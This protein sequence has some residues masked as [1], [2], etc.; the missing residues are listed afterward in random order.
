MTSTS[1]EKTFKTKN[2]NVKMLRQHVW[3]EKRDCLC[4]SFLIS[5][6]N[7]QAPIPKWDAQRL[8]YGWWQW[9]VAVTKA[10]PGWSQT[11]FSMKLFVSLSVAGDDWC[12]S[13]MILCPTVC[14]L[15][16]VFQSGN[17]GIR[18]VTQTTSISYLQQK[19]RGRGDSEFPSRHFPG[20]L[21]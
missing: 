10:D 19:W 3:N 11:S 13:C 12:V 2:I 21:L 15:S 5:S 14:V 16:S 4:C 6:S 8:L 20:S 9:M 17:V 18:S 7:Q 1:K